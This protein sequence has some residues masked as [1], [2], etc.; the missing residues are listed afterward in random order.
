MTNDDNQKVSTAAFETL[1]IILSKDSSTAIM[2]NSFLD[3]QVYNSISERCLSGV[4][5]S[6]NYDGI[7]EFPTPQSSNSNHLIYTS[8]YSHDPEVQ[9]LPAKD[10]IRKHTQSADQTIYSQN[11]QKQSTM[12]E[13]RPK[14]TSFGQISN[15]DKSNATT[16]SIGNKMWL[17]G[18]NMTA[19][20]IK[21]EQS[22]RVMQDPTIHT[23]VQY[24]NKINNERRQDRNTQNVFENDQNYTP[25]SY[26]AKPR[27]FG[28][29]NNPS[30]TAHSMNVVSTNMSSMPHALTRSPHSQIDNYDD[31]RSVNN[32]PAMTEY[33][34]HNM[35]KIRGNQFNS[36]KTVPVTE[37]TIPSKGP[38]KPVGLSG[39]VAQSSL[40]SEAM[41]TGF[42]NFDDESVSESRQHRYSQH[43][44]KNLESRNR[45]KNS[46]SQK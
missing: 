41:H 9:S 33:T 5:A 6:V 22:V 14:V 31:N 11:F 46:L 39:S 1:C 23:P 34:P 12:I 44:N 24:S 36:E 10:E 25:E 38:I 43:S 19:S 26:H 28:N 20:S 16:Q 4:L 8:S 45:S 35:R 42:S 21:S 3:P 15:Y 32:I 18:F 2:L 37:N 30:M 7:V 27:T 13:E 40:Q 29:T 17:P